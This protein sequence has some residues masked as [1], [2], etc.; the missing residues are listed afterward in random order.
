LEHRK[1]NPAVGG[2][3]NEAML[4]DENELKHDFEGFDILLLKEEVINLSEGVYHN[5]E[6][7]VMRFI[8]RKK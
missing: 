4:F 1:A 6:G 3:D 8:G 5:G 2:P 7:S